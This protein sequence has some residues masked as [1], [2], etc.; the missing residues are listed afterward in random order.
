MNKKKKNKNPLPFRLNIVFFVIFILF[1]VLVIQLGVVQILEGKDH[2][3]EIER[4]VSDKSKSPVPRGKIFDRDGDILVDNDPLYSITYTPPKRAQ[5][6]EKLELAEKLIEYMEVDK[7]DID[8]VT[9]NN[10]KEYWYME[11]LNKANDRLSE[12]ESKLD[13]D[14]QYELALDRIDEEDLDEITDE[15]MKVIA[16]KRLLD[17]AYSLTPEVIKNEGISPEEYSKIAENLSELPGINAST[18]WNRKYAE[19]D[20]LR[21][22]LGSIT[23]RNE[24]IPEEKED[25]YLSRGYSRNDRVGKSGLEEEYEDQLRGRKEVLENITTKSGDLIASDVLVDGERGK[26]LVLSM[27]LDFQKKVDD[28]VLKELKSAQ[29]KNPHLEDA[30]A[31]AMDPK[32]G[33]ILALS[34]FHHDKDEGEYENSPLKSFYDQHP[35]GSS[36]KGATIMTGLDAG[37][38][39]PGEVIEDKPV[40]IAGSSTKKSYKPLGSVSDI[41]ALQKSSN[42]YMFYTALRMG[43]EMRTPIPDNSKTSANYVEGVQK[44]Q[45]YFHQFGLGVT[46]GIDFPSEATGSTSVPDNAGA[47]MDQGIGQ[48]DSYTTLQLAQYV[49]TVANGGYRIEPHLVKEIRSPSVENKLGSLYKANDTHVLDKVNIK[50][51]YIERV[52][53]G[54]DKAFNEQGGTGYD[55]W[56]D[57]SYDA[58]GKTGTAEAVLVEDGN[59]ISED[60]ENLSLVGYAPQDDPEIAFAVLIPNLD[61]SKGDDINHKIGRQIMDAYFDKD[62]D[63]DED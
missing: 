43:G 52:Q 9:E 32:T 29:G 45:N 30:M 23:N 4:T 49:S 35:P 47:L 40:K 10:K 53:T 59:V 55:R 27:D 54:F 3:E 20:T 50:N 14:K 1:S 2:Q 13:D 25:F 24:G 56:H 28:I 21:S 8:K 58:A 16:V 62:D 7:K 57:A 31:V 6:E 37:V 63:K 12:K 61:K 41:T 51:E 39:D 42:V 34:G 36:V 48:F 5:P 22:I 60:V 19:K 44:M 15:E 26:D 17:Q 38:I 18:D 33:D 46:T 11:N